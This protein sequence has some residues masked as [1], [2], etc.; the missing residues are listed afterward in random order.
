MVPKSCFTLK[1]QEYKHLHGV[2]S[3][4]YLQLAHLFHR[5]LLSTHWVPHMVVGSGVQK[6]RKQKSALMVLIS[7]ER[8]IINK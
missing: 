8:W 2:L 3:H 7:S 1:M 4:T 6:H 5:Y